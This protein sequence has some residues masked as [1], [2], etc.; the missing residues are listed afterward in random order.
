MQKIQYLKNKN[1]AKVEK[2][3]KQF[4][5]LLDSKLDELEQSA[6]SR[7]EDSKKKEEEAKQILQNHLNE[8]KR[9]YIKISKHERVVNEELQKL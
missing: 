7:V 6:N 1:Q 4:Q 8:I 5:N 9:E 3:Q 2:L